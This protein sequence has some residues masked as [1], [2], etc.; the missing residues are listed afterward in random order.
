MKP[1]VCIVKNSG[2]Q[3]TYNKS[4]ATKLQIQSTNL[5]FYTSTIKIHTI[6]D[7]QTFLPP[8]FKM[9]KFCSIWRV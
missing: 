8:D 9:W 5:K 1:E 4:E 6:L 7:T 2:I 3:Y